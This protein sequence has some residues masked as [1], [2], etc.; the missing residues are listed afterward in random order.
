MASVPAAITE[1]DWLCNTLKN[2][3]WSDLLCI[4][5]KG[6]IHAVRKYAGKTLRRKKFV[7]SVV[8]HRIASSRRT[9]TYV[10][11]NYVF[12]PPILLITNHTQ[13]PSKF[14]F[15]AVKIKK[16]KNF[17]CGRVKSKKSRRCSS[18]AI[19]YLCIIVE[20]K[21][22]YYVESSLVMRAWQHVHTS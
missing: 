20:T 3:P 10:V 11:V 16:K 1:C 22:T 17:L 7:S 15:S 21:G 4:V 19:E 13:V 2:S 6:K 12:K 18:S 14:F 9:T 8:L 5:V